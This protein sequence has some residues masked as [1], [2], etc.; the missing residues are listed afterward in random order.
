MSKFLINLSYKDCCI[1][2]HAL[3]DKLKLKKNVYEGLKMLDDCDHGFLS[4]E[5]KNELKE[6]KEESKTLERFTEE[7]ERNKEN[8]HM[9]AR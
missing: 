4:K 5:S 6:C 3:R 7:I 1:L 2:K 9:K 8:H